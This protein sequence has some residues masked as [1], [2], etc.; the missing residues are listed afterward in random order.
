MNFD[1]PVVRQFNWLFFE[2]LMLKSLNAFKPGIF[3]NP[4][5]EPHSHGNLAVADITV[6]YFYE[7]TL[8]IILKTVW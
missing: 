6:Q 3:L 2:N 8:Y 1:M 4:R 7:E 5:A